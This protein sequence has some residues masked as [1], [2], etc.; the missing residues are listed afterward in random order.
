[1]TLA[2]SRPIADKP[3]LGGAAFADTTNAGGTPA[4]PPW[5]IA[6]EWVLRGIAVG[7]IVEST[8]AFGTSGGAV[9]RPTV[10]GRDLQSA[11]AAWTT[12]PAPR[13]VR[14][15]LDAVP[16]AATREWLGA[17]ASGGLHVTWIP[18]GSDVVGTALAVVPTPDPAG[19]VRLAVA[20]P[21]GARVTLSDDLGA[22]DSMV[23]GGG[24]ATAEGPRPIGLA[25]ATL[26]GSVAR[27]ALADSLLLRPLLVIGRVGWESKFLVRA[28]EERGWRVD[29]RLALTPRADLTQG[30]SSAL[31]DGSRRRGTS[32]S[33][34]Q[35]A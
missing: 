1:M 22:I 31:E 13:D 15:Q 6:G 7:L 3:P 2:T 10:S 34:R 14:V 18:R 24:G 5:R 19:R 17:L 12:G 35:R 33:E 8:V 21:P 11:L 25:S 32:S 20:A 16:S 30:V 9:V 26:A 4:V 23:A 29:L 28:L 27:A